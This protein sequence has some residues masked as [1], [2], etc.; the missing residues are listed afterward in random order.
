MSPRVYPEMSLIQLTDLI[1]WIHNDWP[2]ESK[3]R[4]V[5]T[6][7]ENDMFLK[8]PVVMDEISD[9]NCKHSL[10]LSHS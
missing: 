3:M 2:L 7:L 9:M 10:P 6:C 5:E 4:E 1:T 8:S